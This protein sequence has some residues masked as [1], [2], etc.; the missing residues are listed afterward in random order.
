MG[1]V[2]KQS[3]SNSINSYIGV[4]L[5]ALNT[6][7][8]FPRI[9]APEAY[10]DFQSLMAIIT[11]V[12]TF[13][14]LGF[15]T[16][17]V[18]FFPKLDRDKQSALW[19]FMLVYISLLSLVLGLSL[20]GLKYF[21]LIDLDH[22]LIALI[23]CISIV[24]FELFSALSQYYSKVVLPQFIRN[25]FRR[26]IISSALAISYLM[27]TDIET[28]YLVFGLGYLIHL[29]V[30]IYYARPDMPQFRWRSDLVNQKQVMGYGL[31]VMLAA[32]S[33]ILV[34]R[35][36]IIMIKEL[37]G[38]AEVAF[39]SIAFFIGSVVAVPVKSF[40]ASIRP[41][42][43]K[44]WAQDNLR[45]IDKLYK[46]SALT[47]LA[48]TAFLLLIIMVNLDLFNLI[49]PEKYHFEAFPAV[50]FFIGLS[51]VLKGAT[52]INGMI[53]T[54][55]KKQHF[56]F[57]S[58]LVLIVLTVIGNWLLIPALGLSGA[59][60]ASLIA[61]GLFNIFKILVVQKIYKLIP[62]TKQFWLLLISMGLALLLISM[63]RTLG[64]SMWLNLAIGN[65]ASLALLLILFK[66]TSA[67]DDF[68]IF[69][70]LNR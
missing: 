11:I 64:W 39:Y 60:L 26:V 7:I 61:I 4:A 47:Q 24:Y 52:G 50:V 35:I 23:V 21:D 69:K 31:M 70:F 48:I 12:S 2:A 40:I 68:K 5:G 45:E 8:L 18:V 65:L 19:T 57:Y 42:V 49:L 27:D 43:A 15:P 58:G 1:T 62:F 63:M 41:F 28:F 13:A 37:L 6:M 46:K 29:I 67:L 51:E 53:L 20:G 9:L 17:V 66:Y 33:L 10:G 14:H 59:A 22:S 36:D 25:V 44:A 30:M 54:V 56:N 3:F 55:S 32:G 16:S 38:S 34:S